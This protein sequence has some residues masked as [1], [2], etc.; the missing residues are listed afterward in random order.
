MRYTP[1]GE[2]MVQVHGAAV[3]SPVRLHILY[4]YCLLLFGKEVYNLDVSLNQ[5]AHLS[6]ICSST[7]EVQT[8][9]VTKPIEVY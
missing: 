7:L 3:I 6:M 9:F 5:T 1:G 8:I 4:S 2:K